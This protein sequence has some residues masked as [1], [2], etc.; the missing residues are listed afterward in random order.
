MGVFPSLNALGND[1]GRFRAN[2]PQLIGKGVGAGLHVQSGARQCRHTQGFRIPGT[3]CQRFFGSQQ[4][5]GRVA[6]KVGGSGKRQL[7]IGIAGTQ[8]CRPGKGFSGLGVLALFY[9]EQAKVPRRQPVTG[10]KFQRQ[11]I[12]RF[13]KL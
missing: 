7:D 3:Q 9:L 11:A 13:L 1:F 10:I 2:I 8:S 4:G 6:G 12:P 5:D